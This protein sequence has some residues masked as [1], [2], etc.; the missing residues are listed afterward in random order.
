MK[1]ESKAKVKTDMPLQEERE[2]ERSQR[3]DASDQ[4]AHTKE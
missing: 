4:G 2:D 1:R 3:D